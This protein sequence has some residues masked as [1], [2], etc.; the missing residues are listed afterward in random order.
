MSKEIGLPV[1]IEAGQD[2]PCYLELKSRMIAQGINSEVYKDGPYALK[3]YKDGDDSVLGSLDYGKLR[4]YQEITNRASDLARLEGWTLDLPFPFGRL[5]VAVNPILALKR[6]DKCDSF[7]TKMPFI[8]GQNLDA[9]PYSLYHDDLKMRFVRFNYR[10]ERSFGVVGVSIMP[11]NVKKIDSSLIVTD[12][13]VDI[14][15][16]QKA[17]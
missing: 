5:K 2:W 6:C 7:E 3:V 4:L 11:I 8:P 17:Y 10:I 9:F 13:C 12:L 14:G 1:E 15:Y 16:L